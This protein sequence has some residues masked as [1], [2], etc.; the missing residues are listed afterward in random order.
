MTNQRG[1]VPTMVD[2]W[3]YLVSLSL[4]TF[5]HI[6]SRL[7]TRWDKCEV[8]WP[9]W[10]ASQIGVRSGNRNTWKQKNT[11]GSLETCHPSEIWQFITV[12]IISCFKESIKKVSRRQQDL[13]ATRRN[14]KAGNS[15]SCYSCLSSANSIGKI[16]DLFM[17]IAKTQKIKQKYYVSLIFAFLAFSL[18]R[19]IKI[20]ND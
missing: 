6:L 17:L 7:L 5:V 11:Y 20:R 1:V 19:K 10:P 16:C 14:P 18:G 9:V 15:T 13:A 12:R 8:I 3:H 2:R 4:E